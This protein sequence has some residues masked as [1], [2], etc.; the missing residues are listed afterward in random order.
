MVRNDEDAMDARSLRRQAVRYL[1]ATTVS[2]GLSILLPALFH[3]WFSVPEE[4][5]VAISLVIVLF[6]NFLTLRLFVFRSTGRSLHQFLMF[7]SSSV[8]FRVA[9]YL[10]FLGAFR[11][12]G[13][14][15]IYALLLAL[16]ISFVGKFFFQRA[17][18]F[19]V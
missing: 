18:V 13:L 15:Y 10:M 5:S 12:L 8:A 6:V 2:A 11:M 16:G 9:E 14:N 7:A 4:R 1:I 19:R 17:V 3:E